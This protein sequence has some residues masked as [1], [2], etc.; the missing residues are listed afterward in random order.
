MQS[1]AQHTVFG[2]FW[3]G[4]IYGCAVL[5]RV[6][7]PDSGARRIHRPEEHLFAGPTEVVGRR[8]DITLYLMIVVNGTADK[9]ISI[10][11]AFYDRGI[12]F[13]HSAI[14]DIKSL[15]RSR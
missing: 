11:L 12:R 3:T 14:N 1:L 4:N 2:G 9:H 13:L 8:L 10:D 7:P 5:I 6:H 15:G